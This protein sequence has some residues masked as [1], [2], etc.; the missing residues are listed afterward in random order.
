M[1]TTV[2]KLEPTKVKMTVTVEPKELDPYLDRT[3]ESIG[4]QVSVPGFRKGHV[5]AAVIDA[6]FGFAA[7]VSEAVND[8][9]PELYSQAAQSK[10]LHPMDQPKINV[11]AVPMKAD[12]DTKLKFTAEVEVRPEIKLPS[13]K[14]MS[15][16]I[17][18]AT[19]TDKDVDDRL[20]ELRK[21]F[22]TLV[23][24]DRPAKKGDYVNIDLTATI[25]GEKVDSQ[26]GVSYQIGSG[27]MLDGMDDALETMTAGE[28]TSFEA[29]L[30][31]GKHKGEK[32]TVEVTVNS[33]KEEQL[34]KLDDD[35]AKEASEF[36]TLKEL[37]ESIRKAARVDAGAR[38]AQQARDAFLAKLEEGQD[39]PVPQGVAGQ[40]TR[41]HLSQNGKDP[42]KATDEEKKTAK[43]EAEKELRDQMVLDQLAED[44]KTEVTQ[45]DV[46]NFLATIAQQYGM[47][48]NQFISSIVSNNQLGSAIVEVGRSKAMI[49]AMRQVKFVDKAGKTVD[50]SE[51]LPEE[52]K[53]EEANESKDSD[54]EASAQAAEAAASIADK[55]TATPA[56]KEPAKRSSARKSSSATAKQ[57]TKSAKK[58][59][60]K[61]K[62]PKTSSKAKASDSE[63]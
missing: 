24:V 10:D 49:A 51:Y 12:D 28:K 18:E 26:S 53:Q 30:A 40:L 27:N 17:P 22:G 52:E 13:V 11:E 33:V 43:D 36:D 46:T 6:R 9:V 3:R 41:D 58:T 44:Q 63:K 47:D 8:A 23:G 59:T 34:P 62:S 20:E 56:K 57:A 48:P 4:K 50:L 31:A 54:A 60:S 45:S 2:K 16:D 38:Q 29:P 42:S 39:I 55:M 1:R 7:V 21:R 25:K 15:V 61:A 32:A 37:K 35:F 19:V 5:P 14:G